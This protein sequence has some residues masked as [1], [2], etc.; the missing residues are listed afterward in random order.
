MDTLFGD[1]LC[2]ETPLLSVSLTIMA[3][4]LAGRALAE[5]RRDIAGEQSEE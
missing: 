3:A 4:E 1:V 2:F 5:G